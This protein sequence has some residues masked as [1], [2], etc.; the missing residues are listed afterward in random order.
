MSLGV[1]VIGTGKGSR[2]RAGIHNSV[3]SIGQDTY[4]VIVAT[5]F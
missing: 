5:L 1:V 3:Y 4:D 2:K